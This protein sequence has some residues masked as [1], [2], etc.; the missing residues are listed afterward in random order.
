M[1]RSTRK[2]RK[3]AGSPPGTLIHVGEQKLSSVSF[4]IFEY[5]AESA[6]EVLTPSIE[7][8]QRACHG[9]HESWLN[10]DGL[11]DV[12]LL[13]GLGAVFR[14]HPLVLE[15]ILN[16]DQRPKVDRFEE[17]AFIVCKMLSSHHDQL[18][19]KV[20][21][22]SF[23]IGK[24]FLLSFQEDI[25]DVFDDVRKRL[26][27]GQGKVR[28]AGVDHLL[29]LLLDAVV[30]HY[31]EALELLGDR[32]EKIEEEILAQPSTET[33]HGV[34]ELKR[35]LIRIRRAVWPMRECVS[36]LLREEGQLITDETKVFLRDL[37]DHTVQVIDM[38]ESMRDLAAGM[39]DLYLSTVSNRTNEI[40]RVLTVMSSVFVPLTFIVGV[41][42]MNFED[43]PEL[44]ASWGYPGVLALMTVIAFALL[45]LFRVKR[46]S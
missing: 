9:A 17:Y 13:E 23:I 36:A 29:Y 10:V 31:F 41:Y 35:E 20:E 21:Q 18:E 12:P 25:G 39:L 26:R 1:T 42:G 2:R 33:V 11:H 8:C 32:L 44:K 19:V 7:E 37:Y 14:L 24:H 28:R 27:S 45:A 46:W 16:T 34:Y 40:M 4:S 15:D 3:K 22:I 6:R 38:V 5:T 30:D 43:M